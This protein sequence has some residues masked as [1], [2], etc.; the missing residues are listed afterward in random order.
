MDKSSQKDDNILTYAEKERLIRRISSAKLNGSIEY[1]DETI[2]FSISDPSPDVMADADT[3]YQAEID[4]L[5]SMGVFTLDE[6]YKILEEQGVWTVKQKKELI[7]IDNDIKKLTS[8]L[9]NLQ[10]QKAQKR[11]IIEAIKVAKARLKELSDLRDSLWPHTAEAKAELKKRQFL[12]PRLTKILSNTSETSSL[13]EDSSFIHQIIV[14]YY[15]RQ[16]EE[17]TVRQIARS[18][19]WRNYWSFCHENGHFTF[20]ADVTNLTELQFLLMSWTKIYDFAINSTP[21]PADEI[22]DSDRLFDEWYAGEIK[23]MDNE[24]KKNQ[25]GQNKYNNNY[26]N[27]V[28]QEEVFVMADPE[29]A[30][31]VYD[32][33]DVMMRNK[34]Q[35]RQK[36]IKEKGT[37]KEGDLN[38][39]KQEINMKLNQMAGSMAS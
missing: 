5:K 24:Q 25:L 26:Q 13:L 27:A 16:V 8:A 34:I 35:T 11:Q 10:Y 30:K 19:P 38:D 2:S 23:R 22:L 33:N 15:D 14:Y 32:L 18:S 37:V 17:S 28:G 1:N 21:R 7:T 12:I 39:V 36:E 29:A 6:S 9:P 31:E 3:V 20:S 4:K